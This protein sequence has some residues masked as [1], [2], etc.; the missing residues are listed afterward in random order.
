MADRIVAFIGRPGAGKSHLIKRLT[1]A[2][3]LP[4]RGVDLYGK[5]GKPRRAELL[6]WIEGQQGTVLTESNVV[7][8]S[9]REM[10]ETTDSVVVEVYAPQQV[11]LRRAG[12]RPS[13]RPLG[14]KPDLRVRSSEVDRVLAVVR[15]VDQS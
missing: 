15:G 11:R 6:R 7:W 9:Y 1:E 12:Y 10:L 5:K 2:T 13:T 14:V 3:G 8:P 4:S